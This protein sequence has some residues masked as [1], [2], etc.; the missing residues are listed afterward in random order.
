[1]IWLLKLL[2]LLSVSSSETRL[3]RGQ[4]N[5]S[6]SILACSAPSGLRQD[7]VYTDERILGKQQSRQRNVHFNQ[8]EPQVFVFEKRKPSLDSRFA[9]LF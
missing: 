5:Q 4:G 8:D 9:V 3:L 1:M 7:E 2:L 6:G